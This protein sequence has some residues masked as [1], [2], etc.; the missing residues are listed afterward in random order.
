V[1]YSVRSDQNNE[2]EKKNKDKAA[3][4]TIKWLQAHL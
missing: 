1:V 3:E 4:N 2:D